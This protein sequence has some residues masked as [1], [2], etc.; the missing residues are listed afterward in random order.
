MKN[1][2]KDATELA[3]RLWRDALPEAWVAPPEV[4][5][6][7]ELVRYRKLVRCGPRP[8]PGQSPGPRGYG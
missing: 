8:K 6:L 1:D 4:R 7:R 5:E 3:K 2:I